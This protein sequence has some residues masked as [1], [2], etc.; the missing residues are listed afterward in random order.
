MLES[1]LIAKPKPV[2][3]M[4]KQYKTLLFIA[5][6]LEIIL[7]LFFDKK[8]AAYGPVLFWAIGL[9][10]ILNTASNISNLS[11]SVKKSKPELYKKYSFGFMITRSALGENEFLNALNEDEKQFIEN[12]KIIFKY[13]VYCFLLFAVSA[14][15]LVLK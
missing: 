3:K 12:N 6:A 2:E 8:V 4:K 5:I 13:L 15:V 7:L 10:G 11:K 1:R 14:L 9:F